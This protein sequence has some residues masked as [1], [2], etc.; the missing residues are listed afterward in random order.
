MRI[1]SQN[2]AHGLLS[3]LPPARRELEI[4]KSMAVFEKFL[5]STE[6]DVVCVQE[7]ASE[8]PLSLREFPYVHRVPARGSDVAIASRRPLSRQGGCPFPRAGVGK[9]VAWAS[10]V[11][12]HGAVRV[13]SMHLAVLSPFARRHQLAHA[14][15]VAEASGEPIFLVG[16]TNE[17]RARVFDAWAR[18]HGLVAGEPGPSF[19]AALPAL[20][21]DRAI[22]SEGLR[23]K[24]A[25]SHNAKMSDH[26]AVMFEVWGQSV[27]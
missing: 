16:D 24:E 6:V 22:Y 5:T 10:V 15:S 9:A 8:A 11:D 13:G 21:L 2:L 12:A 18:P 27:A 3:W 19:P 17:P 1:L 20:R 4:A 26:R 25:K 23:V 7:L 14:V